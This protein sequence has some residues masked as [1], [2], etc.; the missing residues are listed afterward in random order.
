M[1]IH[2]YNAGPSDITNWPNMGQTKMGGPRYKARHASQN[3]QITM[4]M[5]VSTTMI[6]SACF[7]VQDRDLWR[8]E[9]VGVL[10]KEGN[11]VQAKI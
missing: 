7:T 6:P 4:R 2:N 9:R 11:E 1:G 8:Q 5:L 10:Q 3:D